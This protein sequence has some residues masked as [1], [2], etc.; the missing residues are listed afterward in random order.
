MNFA[1]NIKII[2]PEKYETIFQKNQIYHSA[3]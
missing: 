2:E 1:I 3:A